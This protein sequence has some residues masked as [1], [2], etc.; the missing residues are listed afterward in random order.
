MKIILECYGVGWEGEAK[1]GSFVGKEETTVHYVSTR[2]K[3]DC[4]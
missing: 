3:V 1:G 2:N 4:L